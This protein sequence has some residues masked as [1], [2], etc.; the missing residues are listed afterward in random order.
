MEIV[1]KLVPTANSPSNLPRSPENLR[2]C[3]H[4]EELV[5]RDLSDCPY[6]GRRMPRSRATRRMSHMTPT[7]RKFALIA[8]AAVVTGVLVGVVIAGG[9]DGGGGGGEPQSVPELAPPPNSSLDE[10]NTRTQRDRTTTDETP[11]EAPVRRRGGPEHPG[12][13][14]ARHGRRRL[15]A[16]GHRAERHAATERQPGRALRAVLPGEPGRLLTAGRA[17]PATEC[18]AGASG[19]IRAQYRSR[20]V[21]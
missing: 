12:A 16:A 7:V 5:G 4:C 8:V 14:A 6:C 9:D 20:A 3:P 21:S 15:A 10:T 1:G 18:R 13:G 11:S 17:R 19:T 2:I